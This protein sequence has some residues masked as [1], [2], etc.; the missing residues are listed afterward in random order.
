LLDGLFEH[1]AGERIADSSEQN[2]AL[3]AKAGQSIAIGNRQDSAE[4]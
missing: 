2:G 4:K 1:P 3:E